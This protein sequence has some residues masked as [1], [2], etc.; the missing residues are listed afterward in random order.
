MGQRVL[1]FESELGS[2]SSGLEGMMAIKG[3]EAL[4]LTFPDAEEYEASMI[5]VG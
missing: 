3:V 2:E 1:V 5:P 4:V